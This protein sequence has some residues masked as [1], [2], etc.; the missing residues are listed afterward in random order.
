MS[1]R[2]SRFYQA[3]I[4][5]PEGGGVFPIE[6]GPDQKPMAY[7]SFKEAVNVAEMAIK[8]G[9]IEAGAKV[10]ILGD[11]LHEDGGISPSA[12]R[13]DNN[14]RIL[15]AKGLRNQVTLGM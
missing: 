8:E 2:P 15:R 11:A 5:Y 9:K 3:L 14:D 13:T 4:V 7:T 10:H 1:N 6:K 12:V